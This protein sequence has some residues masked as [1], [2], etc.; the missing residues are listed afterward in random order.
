MAFETY[1]EP[2]IHQT[3]P[4]PQWLYKMFDVLEVHEEE[5]APWYDDVNNGTFSFVK[6]HEA[7][8]G[9]IPSNWVSVGDSLMKLNPIYGAKSHRPACGLYG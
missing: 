1:L 3:N 9:S 8:K 4:A 6:Y 2:A 5:C 7:D